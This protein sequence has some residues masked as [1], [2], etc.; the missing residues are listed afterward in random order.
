MKEKRIPNLLEVYKGVE[1]FDEPWSPIYP[2][3]T[4]ERNVPV[5]GI[6]DH[7]HKSVEDA[8]KYIDEITKKS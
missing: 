6:I 5:I 3:S 7:G 8:K 4:I 1:I 2:I